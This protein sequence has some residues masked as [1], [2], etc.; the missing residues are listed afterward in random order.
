MDSYGRLRTETLDV[1]DVYGHQRTCTDG[2]HLL[3]KQDV[4]GSIPISSTENK[5]FRQ[6]LTFEHPTLGSHR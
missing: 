4:V 6:L 3:C 5:G 2:C 1:P